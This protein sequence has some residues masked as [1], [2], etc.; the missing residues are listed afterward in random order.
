V[1]KSRIAHVVAAGC[2]LG[3]RRSGNA[4]GRPGLNSSASSSPGWRLFR[5]HGYLVAGEFGRHLGQLVGTPRRRVSSQE[6]DAARQPFW[7]AIDPFGD[8]SRYLVTTKP[9]TVGHLARRPPEPHPGLLERPTT[10]GIRLR[11][12]EHGLFTDRRS[13]LDLPT[14]AGAMR[15]YLIP[16]RLRLSCG[17]SCGAIGL[18]LDEVMTFRRETRCRATYLSDG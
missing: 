16:G 12:A 3:R 5:H 7:L 14:L 15:W 18:A 13:Q 6:E 17:S 8:G 2:R 9:A 4:R 10:V 1:A 11:R